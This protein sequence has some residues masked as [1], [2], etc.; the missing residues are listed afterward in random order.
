[1]LVN[2]FE[3][4][5]AYTFEENDNLY[6]LGM[7]FVKRL[8]M[9]DNIPVLQVIYNNRPRI[10]GGTEGLKKL[11]MVLE[12]LSDAEMIRSLKKLIESLNEIDK[13][14]F[15]KITAVDISINRLFYDFKNKCIKYVI[16]PV[17]NECDFHD[18]VAW[19]WQFRN[20]ILILLNKIL[21]NKPEKYN[22][23]YSVINSVENDD[24]SIIAYMLNYDF[25]F[26]K[27]SMHS[28]HDSKTFKSV[29]LIIEHREKEE[30]IFFVINK[31]KYILGKSSKTADGVINNY[32]SISRNHCMIYRKDNLFMVED[33]DST[34]GTL[35]NG[36]KL[37]PHEKYYIN[38]GDKLT[39]AD[40]EFDVVIE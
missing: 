37:N 23:A 13:S 14:D 12:E 3:E 15:I 9:Y 36:Y 22:E 25:N 38:D 7:K 2:E 20:T 32:D 30:N 40:L 18:D 24:K 4:H 1:M 21:K 17:R 33:L 8:D 31:E 39:L 34:N 16:L 27:I 19:S 35:I 5:I 28:I 6:N 11:Y 26:N 29:K 10:L